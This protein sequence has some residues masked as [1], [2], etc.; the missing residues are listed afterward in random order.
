MILIEIRFVNIAPSNLERL[1]KYSRGRRTHSF[2]LD[3]SNALHQ[4]LSG[5]VGLIKL[6]FDIV[7]EDLEFTDEAVVATTVIP[8]INSMD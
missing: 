6:K 3:I 7:K 1:R 2:T 8:R 4:T 5:I